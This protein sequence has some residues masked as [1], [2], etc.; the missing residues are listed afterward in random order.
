MGCGNPCTQALTH[1]SMSSRRFENLPSMHILTFEN[2]NNSIS[3]MTS[4]A[5][6]NNSQ[7][8]DDISIV[9]SCNCWL[10]A[11]AH[12]CHRCAS[13]LASPSIHTIACSSLVPARSSPTPTTGLRRDPR[14]LITTTTPCRHS[15]PTNTPI[16]DDGDCEA[17]TRNATAHTPHLIRVPRKWS[18]RVVGSYIDMVRGAADG[19]FAMHMLM[20]HLSS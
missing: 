17:Y 7:Y 9:P 18:V 5:Q 19:G 10:L 20:R 8:T 12:L 1:Y 11:V 2:W 14:Q 6:Q 4:Q 13:L 15:L 3:T 16:E